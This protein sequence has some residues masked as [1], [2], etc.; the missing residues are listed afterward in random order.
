MP[1]RMTDYLTCTASGAIDARCQKLSFDKAGHVLNAPT[2]YTWNRTSSI[3][4]N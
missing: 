2:G 3:A 4:L 1:D